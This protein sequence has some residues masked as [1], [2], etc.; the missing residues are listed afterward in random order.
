MFCLGTNYCS[1]FFLIVSC[2]GLSKYI[3]GN[4]RLISCCR[5]KGLIGCL[6]INWQIWYTTWIVCCLLIGKRIKKRKKKWRERGKEEKIISNSGNDFFLSVQSAAANVQAWPWKAE[7]LRGCII[8]QSNG[9]YCQNI[10]EIPFSYMLEQEDHVD[11]PCRP[12]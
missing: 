7:S 5:V 3:P 12:R 2:I 1:C 9:R 8:R 10:R 4:G 6:I 11:S